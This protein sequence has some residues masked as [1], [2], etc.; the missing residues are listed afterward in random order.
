[1]KN[2]TVRTVRL[3]SELVEKIKKLADKENRNFTNMV[4]TLLLNFLRKNGYLK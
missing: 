4:E 3:K 2:H 1:M